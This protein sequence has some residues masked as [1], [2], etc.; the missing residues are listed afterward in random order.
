MLLSVGN[1]RVMLKERHDELNLARLNLVL[2]QNRTTLKGWRKELAL[3]ALGTMTVE[4]TADL[5]DVVPHG[6]DNDVLLG[7]ISTLR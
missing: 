2:A 1:S 3:D 5:N 7:L 4:C 6:I